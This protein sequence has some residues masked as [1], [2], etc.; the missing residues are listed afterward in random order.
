MKAL[1]SARKRAQPSAHVG[2]AR[3]T[4]GA[5]RHSGW[6]LLVGLLLTCACSPSPEQLLVGRWRESQWRYE[7]LGNFELASLPQDRAHPALPSLLRH[8]AEHWEFRRDG[9]LI[10]RS[11]SGAQRVGRWKLKGRGHLLLLEGAGASGREAYEI[12]QLRDG[13]LVLHYDIGLEIRGIARLTFTKLPTPAER[14]A[15]AASTRERESWN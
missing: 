12:K 13:Q 2:S 4:V 14:T 10:V 7:Q 5:H 9:A 3:R 15:L 6:V 1:I 8:E 11:A